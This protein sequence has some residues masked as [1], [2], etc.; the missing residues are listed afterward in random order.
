MLPESYP[1][2]KTTGPWD[3]TAKTYAVHCC[4]FSEVMDNWTRAQW[5]QAVRLKR[6]AEREKN[7]S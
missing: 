7:K 4:A 5:A 2:S 3:R 6:K 1:P